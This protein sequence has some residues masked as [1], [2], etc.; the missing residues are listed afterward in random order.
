MD[1]S[2]FVLAHAIIFYNNTHP[3]TQCTGFWKKSG[4]PPSK[5][6]FEKPG[7]CGT[8]LIHPIRFRFGFVTCPQDVS[9]KLRSPGIAV[10]VSPGFDELIPGQFSRSDVGFKRIGFIEY[11]NISIEY[12]GI[13]DYEMI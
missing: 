6:F 8:L 3:G 13:S 7:T 12:H 5:K 10:S 4:H 1:K 11:F 2:G 9:V